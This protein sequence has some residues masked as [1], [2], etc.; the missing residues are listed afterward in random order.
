[1]KLPAATAAV[2]D[3]LLH[4]LQDCRRLP[5]PKAGLPHLR[6]A[7]SRRCRAPLRVHLRI[8]GRTQP[9][10]GS[11]KTG[12]CFEGLLSQDRNAALSFPV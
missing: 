2:L 7:R 12:K 4:E 6:T 9:Q 10:L 3:S 8:R 5:L 11:R 1:M